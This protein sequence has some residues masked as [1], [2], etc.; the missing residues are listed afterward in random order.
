VLAP[1]ITTIRA[2]AARTPELPLGAST[3]SSE[4]GASLPPSAAPNAS[5]LSPQPTPLPLS[6]E[7]LFLSYVLRIIFLVTPAVLTDTISTPALAIVYYA[8]LMAFL[9]GDFRGDSRASVHDTLKRMFLQV[10]SRK[11]PQKVGWETL[12]RMFHV[13]SRGLFLGGRRKKFT[14]FMGQPNSVP[15][16]MEALLNAT[17]GAQWLSRRLRLRERLNLWVADVRHDGAL[18]L[19]ELA[20][21][22]DYLAT[23]EGQAAAIAVKCTI[24]P[25]LDPSGTRTDM[26]WLVFNWDMPWL[27]NSPSAILVRELTESLHKAPHNYMTTVADFPVDVDI[28]APATPEATPSRAAAGGKRRCRGRGGAAAEVDRPTAK[29]RG[30]AVAAYVPA[31]ASLPG[32]VTS[33]VAP[34]RAWP[35]GGWAVQLPLASCLDTTAAGKIGLQISLQAC[36]REPDEEGPHAF[37]LTITQSKVVPTPELEDVAARVKVGGGMSAGCAN[38]D[39]M[40]GVDRMSERILR[41]RALRARPLRARPLGGPAAAT[42]PAGD[43]E[44]TDVEVDNTRIWAGG[45]DGMVDELDGDWSGGLDKGPVARHDTDEAE[46]AS[47]MR[48]DV[49]AGG[50]TLP[51]LPCMVLRYRPPKPRRQYSF[52]WSFCFPKPLSLLEVDVE[53]QGGRLWVVIPVVPVVCNVA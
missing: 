35:L 31:L 42:G 23:P 18:T 27:S 32:C 8:S 14:H 10:D 25:G 50:P 51:V 46:E 41:S 38:V 36:R 15:R 3:A 20:G 53:R 44:M 39:F 33:D 24:V 11:G 28:E 43:T 12:C 22:R 16:A 34:C 49:V 17:G 1:T 37:I 13:C 30:G 4:R 45:E 19:A 21:L 9:G 29:A 26:A 2:A 40:L 5:Q 48:A 7:E 47:V 6:E 52:S